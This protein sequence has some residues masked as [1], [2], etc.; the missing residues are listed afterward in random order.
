MVWGFVCSG[1]GQEAL[2]CLCPVSSPM[3]AQFPACISWECFHVNIALPYLLCVPLVLVLHTDALYPQTL[4]AGPTL[5][6]AV[7]VL[8][9]PLDM[10][11]WWVWV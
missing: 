6:G 1:A 8:R 2:L 4:T 5:P 10:S 11:P 9:E 7:L 3:S